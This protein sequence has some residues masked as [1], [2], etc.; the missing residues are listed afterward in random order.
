MTTD[1]SYFHLDIT[2]YGATKSTL[3]G[4]MFWS[5]SVPF[6]PFCHSFY[7][8]AFAELTCDIPDNGVANARFI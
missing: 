3:K 7:V 5:V 6:L 1:N 8:F 2:I 4:E